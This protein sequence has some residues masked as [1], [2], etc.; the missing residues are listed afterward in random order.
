MSSVRLPRIF[1]TTAF[2]QTTLYALVLAVSVAGLG[3]VVFW[4]FQAALTRHVSTR[5]ES[6]IAF[7]EAKYRAE[8][9]EELVE[10][11]QE[12]MDSFVSGARL[13]YLV[14]NAQGDRLAGNLPFMP[15]RAGWNDI[16]I[17]PNI[18]NPDGIRLRAF[19]TDL[20]HGVRLAIG[21]DL[22]M[23]HEIDGA[24]RTALTWLL[25]A[26]LLLSLGGGLLL[27]L[28]FLRRVDSITRTAAAIIEGDLGQR[29]PIR[30]TNDDFDRLSTTLN[31]MLNRI[32]E[33]MESLRQVSNDIAH[34]LRT[35]LARLRHKLEEAQALSSGPEQI[36]MLEASI[37]VTDE[38]LD[39]FAALLR[40]AQVEAGT[41]RAGFQAVDLSE[42][43]ENVAHAFDAAAEAEGN[44]LISNV[45]AGLVIQGDK[46]LLTQM[47]ANLL[48]NA[49]RHTPAKSRIEIKLAR[50]ASG[51]VG[52]VE[53][54]G[55]GVPAEEHEHIFRRFYRLER[56]RTTPGNGLGLAIV[57][58]IANVHRI[59]LTI[60]DRSPGFSIIMRF[61][62]ANASSS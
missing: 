59:R 14:V 53:D 44:T 43:F 42:I 38:I 27:S 52:S 8:G 24:A 23:M 48:E 62:N 40:I 26:F 34:D 33:L 51:L 13:E 49:I 5:I 20:A 61:F 36:S 39:T 56:S 3:T 35:P 9:L 50:D 10:E 22:E 31:Q 32:T 17:A 15:G 29:I 21:D 12:R 47:L 55:P 54:D 11:V 16:V 45:Q 58:A 4:T 60:V 46:E 30:G 19:V 41:R 57:A 6:E 2:R 18:R 25:P 37:A 7:F 1:R 28:G